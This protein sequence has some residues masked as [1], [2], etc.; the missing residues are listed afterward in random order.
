MSNKVPEMLQNYIMYLDGT[1]QVATVD[2]TMPNIQAVT[3]T[4]QGAGIGGVADV[5]V[6]GHTQDM[7][8][9]VNY[10]TATVEARALLVQKYHHIE[11]WGALQHLDAG[12]G[13]YDT[14]NHRVVLK[15]MPKG[16]NLGVMNPGEL[17]GKSMEFNVIY[18]KETVD[19]EDIREIDKFNMV[20]KIGGE[21]L[22]SKVR[23]SIGI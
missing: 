9:T 4:I 20:Y 23:S 18:V 17:Q 12:E 13:T 22:L 5:P 10:R 14:I 1:R 15:A 11:L 8:M 16:D 19:G 2:V 21:D 7:V 6:Q 3:Q